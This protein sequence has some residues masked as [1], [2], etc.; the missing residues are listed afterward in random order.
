MLTLRDDFALVQNNNFVGVYY[1]TNALCDHK[2]CASPHE[3]I[4][5]FLDLRL[6]IEVNT[7]GRVIQDENTRVEE[8]GAGNSN[9]LL[10]SAGERGT[11][12]PNMCV[13]AIGERQDEVVCLSSFRSGFDL[14][15]R[16]IRFPKSDVLTDRAAEQRCFL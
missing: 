15:L 12:F 11:A 13:I 10:L 5:C 6:R 14:C 3:S 8:Q 16:S 1:G 7:R 9:A 4:E 2:G